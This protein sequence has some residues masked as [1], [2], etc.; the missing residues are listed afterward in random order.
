VSASASTSCTTDGPATSSA[1]SP[2]ISPP[3]PTPI[4]SC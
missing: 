1:P 2:H 4:R 3:A